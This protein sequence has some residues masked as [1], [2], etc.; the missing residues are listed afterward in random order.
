MLLYQG[1]DCNALK[2]IVMIVRKHCLNCL[3]VSILQVTI[4]SSHYVFLSLWAPFGPVLRISFF[5]S[6]CISFFCILY[7]LGFLIPLTFEP[8]SRPGAPRCGSSSSFSATGSNQNRKALLPSKIFQRLKPVFSFKLKQYLTKFS[9]MHI[10]HRALHFS[11]P[12]IRPF[13]TWEHL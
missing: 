11:D 12:P 6:F 1:D 2:M 5:I 10:S 4:F 9:L 13:T 3:F 7:F 8:R